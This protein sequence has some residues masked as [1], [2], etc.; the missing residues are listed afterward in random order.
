LDHFIGR[1][2]GVAIC[3]SAAEAEIIPRVA[4]ACAFARARADVGLENMS[5]SGHAHSSTDNND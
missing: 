1:V 5:V 4:F 2:G 3:R